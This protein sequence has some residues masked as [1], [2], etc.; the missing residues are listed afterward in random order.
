LPFRKGVIVLEFERQDRN[1]GRALISAVHEVQLAGAVVEC[2]G[3]RT[4]LKNPKRVGEPASNHT[5]SA[6]HTMVLANQIETGVCPGERGPPRAGDL[7]QSFG[8]DPAV[9]GRVY[10][11]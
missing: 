3:V 5:P 11:I 4:T 9:T 7:Q 8:L 6:S 10:V 2:V 1:F